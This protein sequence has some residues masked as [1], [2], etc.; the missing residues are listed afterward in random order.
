M[1][2]LAATIRAF[3]Y[4]EQY[5]ALRGEVLAAIEQVL[6]SGTLILGPRVEAFET[7]FAHWLG[8]GYAIG[9][10]N[11]TDALALALRALDIGPGDEVL[12]VSNTAIPT[13]SAIRMVGATPVFC[14]IDPRTLL[15]DLDDAENRVTPRTKAIVPVHLYGNAV[16]M[17][18]VEEFAA[19]NLLRIVED[20]AQAC[21]T[22]LGGQMAGTFGDIGCFS[23]YPTKNLGA[24]GDGGLCFT[25][26]KY[27]AGVLR[28]LRMYGIGD[29][30][31]AEREG[32]NSRLDELQAA[33]LE[34]KL[35][36]LD[37]WLA[38][39]RA[40]A[41]EYDR[42][43]GNHVERPATTADARHS[44]HLYVI[45]S[46][47]RAALAARLKAEGIGFGIHYPTPIHLMRGYSFLQVPEGSLPHTERAAERVL[48]LPCYP[49]LSL[50]AVAKIAAEVINDK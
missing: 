30:Y 35:R 31:Y 40:I 24:Y 42:L 7:A 14:D 11:G 19:R 17:R 38:A 46:D 36:H 2:H 9:V 44:F 10:G 22:T 47:D 27:L 21:G 6:A 13:V 34:V 45:E 3:D 33:I 43:L 15:I 23:F 20:V 25:R 50:E 12:T 41:A 37:D 4:L 28:Q 26:D 29:T 18:A 48:S 8:G 16:D 5:A 39:R 49:E 32:I 1:K